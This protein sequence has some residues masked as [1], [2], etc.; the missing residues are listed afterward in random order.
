MMPEVSASR[1]WMRRGLAPL[2]RGSAVRSSRREVARPRPG[3]TASRAGLLSARMSGSWWRKSRCG[4]LGMDLLYHGNAA[5]ED[6]VA[7][8]HAD[9]G[10]VV[11]FF[12]VEDV[13]VGDGFAVLADG[14]G[15]AAGVGLEA[16]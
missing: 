6:A 16:A 11:P 10:D 5:E 3:R 7:G 1:R 14:R 2:R 4:G 13:C 9:E 15:D 8:P 12:G